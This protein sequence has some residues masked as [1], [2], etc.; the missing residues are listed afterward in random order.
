[1]RAALFVSAPLI[2][3]SAALKGTY[4]IEVGLFTRLRGIILTVIAVK[5]VGLKTEIA[6][7]K[8]LINQAKKINSRYFYFVQ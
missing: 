8:L 7:F 3:K 5:Q 6:Y 4:L 2:L 1:M